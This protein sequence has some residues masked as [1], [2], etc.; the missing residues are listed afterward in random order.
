MFGLALLVTA[1]VQ[2]RATRFNKWIYWA[3]IVASTTFGTTLADFATRSLGIG[4]TGGSLL[5]LGL[6]LLSLF[7]WKVDAG[8]ISADVITSRKNEIHYWVTITFSQ[9][10]G[11]AL[12][13][14]F[15]DTAGLGYAGSTA[16]FTVVL[17]I[18]AALY[19]T[20]RGNPV[21]L[22]LG[23]VHHHTPVRRG[24]RKSLRQARVARRLRDQPR[25]A[26][27]H[28]P[29][30]DG[31]LPLDH[32]AACESQPRGAGFSVEETER[33]VEMVAGAMIGPCR[34]RRDQNAV[35]LGQ[36]HDRAHVRSRFGRPTDAVGALS[37]D[38][39][40]KRKLPGDRLG[41]GDAGLPEVAVSPARIYRVAAASEY[42]GASGLKSL[43]HPNR[44]SE[45]LSSR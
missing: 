42:A 6:V 14:W 18:I 34:A 44:Q 41:E 43:P 28:P 24:L 17:A 35:I 3:T 40:A 27:Q 5:L 1:W 19:F 21:L 26:H 38:F 9:T 20:R 8:R 37:H 2:L 36:P 7:M 32:A 39:G 16:V 22:I 11:T 12:G 25:A 10:L 15:A 13:D 29:G 33:R 4:Y 30:S 45:T 23:R 31:H